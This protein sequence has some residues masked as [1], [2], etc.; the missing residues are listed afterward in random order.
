MVRSPLIRSPQVA[1][2]ITDKD[3]GSLIEAHDLDNHTGK[4][5]GDFKQSATP[6]AC[7]VWLELPATEALA[8][9]EYQDP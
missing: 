1:F 7:P 3:D 2:I 5:Y 4:Y 6:K 8:G 9:I